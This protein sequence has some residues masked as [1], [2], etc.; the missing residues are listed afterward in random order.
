[1]I[2]KILFFVSFLPLILY[3]QAFSK[4]A[5]YKQALKKNANDEKQFQLQQELVNI[6]RIYN[7]D[8]CLFY[9]KK[10]FGLIRKNEWNPKKGRALLG[11]V[12]Y[13]TEKNNIKSAYKYN[14]E[15]F[16]INKDNKD[17]SALADNYYMFARLYHQK[18]EHAQAVR[19]YLK[20]IDVGT[21][22]NNLWIVCSAYRSLAFL[23]LDESNK[24]KSYENINKALKIANKSNLLEASGF[25][26][27]VLGEIDRSFGNAKEAQLNFLKSY[28]YFKFT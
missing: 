7:P 15:S 3:S 6:Y 25:C 18:G 10:N 21:Q 17:Q 19:N 20:S 5:F 4:L 23:Y 2:K 22:S 13:Y 28:Q 16:K 12:S 24:E 9:T 26:Y 11:L 8:S 1:M 27:G 14:Q